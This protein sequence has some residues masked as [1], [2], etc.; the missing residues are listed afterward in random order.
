M[1]TNE[2]LWCSFPLA[3]V[4]M[5]IQAPL[6]ALMFSGHFR[7]FFMSIEI[8]WNLLEFG[9]VESVA[10]ET[11]DQ[12]EDQWDRLAPLHVLCPAG[13]RPPACSLAGWRLAT[14]MAILDFRLLSFTR[15]RH[16]SLTLLRPAVGPPLKRPYGWP[17]RRAGGVRPSVT[18]LDT[19]R[20][21]PMSVVFSRSSA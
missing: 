12:A 16:A 14:H 3:F 4:L 6:R 15:A 1:N 8:L 7:L 11:H 21:K 17:S 18:L 19:P 9:G 20:R 2:M 10:G 5:S 13:D